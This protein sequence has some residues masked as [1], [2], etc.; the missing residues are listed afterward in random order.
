MKRT[1]YLLI[2]LMALCIFTFLSACGKKS[3]NSAV[4]PATY[5]NNNVVYSY[6]QQP[7]SSEIL[8]YYDRMNR[9]CD[10][11]RSRRER[12]H[13]VAMAH[14]FLAQYPQIN[15]NIANYSRHSSRYK[16]PSISEEHI[17]NKMESYEN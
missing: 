6:N 17:R 13:C 7:C 10:Y 9:S 2:T 4:E 3:D 11:A 1:E 8:S 15:C 14:A 16:N 5:P 12:R